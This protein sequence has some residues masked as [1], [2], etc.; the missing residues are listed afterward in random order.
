MVFECNFAGDRS[1]GWSST[2]IGFGFKYF[3]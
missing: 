1:P 3:F 2:E